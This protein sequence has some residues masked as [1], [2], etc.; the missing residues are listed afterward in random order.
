MPVVMRWPGGMPMLTSIPLRTTNESG[1]FG[2]VSFLGTSAFH[3]ARSLPLKSEV[4]VEDA[5]SGPPAQP[6][7]M[8]ART[9]AEMRVRFFITLW[10]VG[11]RGM[12]YTS[13]HET[14]P[15]PRA[16]PLGLR[17]DPDVRAA[18]R[19]VPGPGRPGH[20]HGL[21]ELDLRDAEGGAGTRRGA[22]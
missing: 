12:G 1:A 18:R 5:P 13:S 16:P 3:P 7:T 10:Y 20:R 8:S 21:R 6:A 4:F 17:P 9:T 22:L 19:G 2:S 14:L 11:P 15:A